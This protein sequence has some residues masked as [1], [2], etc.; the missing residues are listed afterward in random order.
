MRSNPT[1]RQLRLGT[2][3]RKLRERAGLTSTQ[4]GKL[5]G[6]QQN[7][8]SNVEA[9]RAGVSPERVRTL[10][11]HYDCG[12]KALVE[13][14]SYMA[15][16]RIRGWWEEYREILSHGLLDLAELEHHG[17]ALRTSHTAGL[18]G[19]LQTTDHAREVFRQVVPALPPPEVEYRL[20][21]RI[22]RQSVV[23]REDPPPYR[24][25]IHEAALHMEFGGP[26]V[27]RQQLAHLLTMSERERVTIQVIPF[28]AG[29]YPGAGQPIYYVHGPVPQLDTVQ[30]DQA[31]GIVLLDAEAQ[32]NKY[33]QVLARLESIALDVAGSRDLIHAVAQNL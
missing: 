9:G 29:A 2:E 31:H 17:A 10:A 13:A 26:T 25:V 8:I 33:R 22:K 6:V 1:G 28:R 30:L 3:L 12:D 18:P 11:S 20:S 5:L 7:Q 16:E 21:F 4:A 32:L 24:A 15:T 19:L 14:L 27:A 23:F